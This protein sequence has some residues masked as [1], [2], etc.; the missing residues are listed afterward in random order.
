MRNDTRAA[1]TVLNTAREGKGRIKRLRSNVVLT[2]LAAGTGLVGVASHADAAAGPNDAGTNCHGVV[3]SYFST[4]GMAPG[5]LHE[6]FGLSVQ[7]VQS[8]ADLLCSL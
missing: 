3:L 6:Q 8:N 2:A 5:L 7:D 1:L 4:S